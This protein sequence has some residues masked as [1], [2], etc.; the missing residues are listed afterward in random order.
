MF[1][2]HEPEF[3][4][5]PRRRS[6]AEHLVPESKGGTEARWNIAAACANCNI[7]RKDYTLAEWLVILPERLEQQGREVHFEVCLKFLSW[8]ANAFLYRANPAKAPDTV[9]ATAPPPTELPPAPQ[10]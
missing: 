4:A 6:T 9:Q 8:H 1:L 5:Y 10:G 3:Q 2:P 7:K